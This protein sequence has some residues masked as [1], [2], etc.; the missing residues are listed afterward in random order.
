MSPEA[1]QRGGGPEPNPLAVAVLCHRVVR[2]DGQLSGYSWGV[3][4]ERAV[5]A[6]G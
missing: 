2:A 1:G 5:A 6:D 4:R 3:E